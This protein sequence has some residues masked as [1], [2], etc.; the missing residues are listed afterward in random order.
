MPAWGSRCSSGREMSERAAT[1]LAIDTLL[2]FE[3]LDHNLTD[4]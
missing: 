3:S 4:R 2:Q 1:V